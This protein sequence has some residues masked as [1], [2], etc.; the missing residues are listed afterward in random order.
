MFKKTLVTSLIC[1]FVAATAQATI[2]EAEWSVSGGPGSPG[3]IGFNYNTGGSPGTSGWT[4]DNEF[5]INEIGNGPTSPQYRLDSGHA[6]AS[7]EWLNTELV[8]T[9]FATE[10]PGDYRSAYGLAAELK[11]TLWKYLV[12]VRVAD[13]GNGTFTTMVDIIDNQTGPLTHPPLRHSHVLSDTQINPHKYNVE[14]NGATGE[15]TLYVDDVQVATGLQAGF[16]LGTTPVDLAVGDLRGSWGSPT[17]HPNA[18]AHIHRVAWSDEVII[19][20][21]AT[22][23]LL[24]GGG[25]LAV[26]RR[27]SKS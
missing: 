24:L 25:L 3:G 7:I 21:P 6:N 1:M 20:E 14:M 15:L 4:G 10:T 12:G 8:A 9:V 13:N 27:R 2:I 19:P 16:G 5:T 17:V 11:N 18:H 22:I 23:S 26:R